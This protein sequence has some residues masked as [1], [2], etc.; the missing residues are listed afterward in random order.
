MVT[1]IHTKRK[2]EEAVPFTITSIIGILYLFYIS[3][4]LLI[5]YYITL[6]MIAAI[7]IYAACLAVHRGLVK[8]EVGVLR[9][10]AK[11]LL[12]PGM[13][14][15]TFLFLALDLLTRN[16]LVTN[17]DEL[18]LWAAYPKA[19][20]FTNQLQLGPDALIYDIMQSYPPGMALFQY[21]MQKLNGGFVEAKLFWSYGIFA[22]STLLPALK[23]FRWKN[24][25]W[26]IL[27][28]VSV[29]IVPMLFSNSGFD[30]LYMY[31]T[32]YVDPL[33]GLLFSYCLFLAFQ[34]GFSDLYATIRLALGLGAL[35]LMKDAGATLAV[36]ALAMSAFIEKNHNRSLFQNK[37]SSRLRIR[38]LIAATCAIGFYLLWRITITRYG[39]VSIYAFDFRNFSFDPQYTLAF[40]N[41]LVS[42]SVLHTLLL[43]YS[44]GVFGLSVL[45]TELICGVFALLAYLI[46]PKER[47]KDV[48]RILV[49]LLISNLLYFIG[50]YMTYL[51]SY[52]K[53]MPSFERYAATILQ[54]NITLL[55]CCIGNAGPDQISAAYKQSRWV[56]VNMAVAVVLIVTL[57]PV[58]IKPVQMPVASES[59]VHA[60]IIETAVEK[61]G[62]STGRRRTSVYLAFAQDDYDI[63][64]HRIYFDLLSDTIFVEL[65]GLGA[66]MISIP[67]GRGVDVT[68]E[69]I[70]KAKQVFID[71]LAASHCM[72]IYFVVDVDAAKE[73]M[74]EYFSQGTSAGTM[75]QIIY[76]D[77]K[78]TSF[79]KLDTDTA[80]LA[81]Y[82]AN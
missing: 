44:I 62:R 79:Q 13:A 10:Y 41:E 53:A 57:F 71:T 2:A 33:L 16:N 9:R 12:T 15:F 55:I 19:L 18:R 26:I 17:W 61:S 35:M 81:P 32:L 31:R 60:R 6:G 47:R 28:A 78:I 56:K 21:F 69:A 45:F 65:Y 8:K 77:N 67:S 46:Y 22:I 72:Y 38:Y 4:A 48:K 27:L 34:E 68:P 25:W 14:I 49:A 3:N 70:A 1:V 24:W 39:V 43:K 23:N 40:L 64:H 82:V 66:S 54:A 74:P 30:A 36:M 51:F 73:Q 29:P 5:G 52:Q 37:G 59:A 80:A 76:T 20:Y 63:R 50:I 58:Y 7:Y 75:Y 11:Q 42:R